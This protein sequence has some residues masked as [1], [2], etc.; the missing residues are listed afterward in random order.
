M[1]INKI[2]F[3]S[4]QSQNVDF[5]FNDL[6]VN[7][8]GQINNQDM[9]LTTNQEIKNAIK[10]AINSVD[11]ENSIIQK[12]NA[13]SK[14]SSNTSARQV[15]NRTGLPLTDTFTFENDVTNSKGTVYIYIGNQYR[16]GGSFKSCEEV[17]SNNL[18]E[19]QKYANVYHL[20]VTNEDLVNKLCQQYGFSNSFNVNKILK[21]VDGKFVEEISQSDA[22]NLD[23]LNN[24][25]EL[26]IINYNITSKN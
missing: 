22:L 4:L 12:E 5:S 24:I 21:F 20:D 23:K 6:D 11:E 13:V 17:A 7:N 3:D 26:L 18:S 15:S 8:D 1:N 25:A 10:S 16:I 19:I 14:E 9:N 2:L